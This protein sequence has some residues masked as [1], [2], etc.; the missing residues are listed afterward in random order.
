MTSPTEILRIDV[1]NHIGWHERTD[2]LSGGSLA[3]RRSIFER[4]PYP[5][6]RWGEDNAFINGQIRKGAVVAPSREYRFHV[7][8]IHADN[9]CMGKICQVDPSAVVPFEEVKAVI[10]SDWDLYFGGNDGLPK[11]VTI[12]L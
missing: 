3:F 8:R 10:G 1:R 4:F 11:S 2:R 12:V 7:H 9:S 5:N 6:V